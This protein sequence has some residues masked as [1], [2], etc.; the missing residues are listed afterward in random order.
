MGGGVVRENG[1][2]A[3]LLVSH[4]IGA[5]GSGVAYAVSSAE[6]LLG[7]FR[8]I[9]SSATVT[10]PIGSVGRLP[11]VLALPF[12]ETQLLLQDAR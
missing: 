4:P 10:G 3:E 8:H 6:R 5:V 9:G 2:Y 12:P 1:S 11:T 7:C